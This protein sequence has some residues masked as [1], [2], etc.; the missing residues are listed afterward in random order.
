MVSEVFCLTTVTA[1]SGNRRFDVS[2]IIPSNHSHA[3][4]LELTLKVCCQSVTPTE[5]IIVD[6]SNERGQSPEELINRC[7]KLEINLI[8]EAVDHAFPGRARNIGLS[9]ATSKFLAFLD[10]RTIPCEHWLQNAKLQHEDPTLSGVWGLTS[11][12]ARNRFEKLIRDGFFGQNPR[13]TLPGSVFKKE[14]LSITGSL[15][16]WV[17]AGEDTDWI[18]RVDLS[19]LNFGYPQTAT[20]NYMGLINQDSVTLAKKW[21]RNYSSSSMLPHLFPYKIIVWITFYLSIIL[22]ALNWNSLLAGWDTESIMYLPNV[23]KLAGLIPIFA[24][25]TTRGLIMPHKRGVPKEA[26]LPIRWLSIA[27]VCLIG[28]LTRALVLLNPS[29]IQKRT[30]EKNRKARPGE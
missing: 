24:Y 5:I 16:T 11:F 20:L 6:T 18:Q 3:E 4:L 17:R 29:S 23:T 27:L 28:D 26:L 10:V 21:A 30:Q 7:D 25:L 2:V 9:R 13:R 22:L 14:I 15:V 19:D 8:Y 12:E 1:N